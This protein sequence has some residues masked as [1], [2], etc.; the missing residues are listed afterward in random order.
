MFPAR[1]PRRFSSRAVIAF[2]MIAVLSG[3]AALAAAA[4]DFSGTYANEKVTLVLRVDDTGAGYSGTITVGGNTYR[5]IASIDS[6]GFHGA[7]QAN[8]TPFPITIEPQADGSLV[9]ASG[10]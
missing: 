8:D 4:N 9:L 7:F 6:K 1:A 10:E 5:C 3:S 2:A